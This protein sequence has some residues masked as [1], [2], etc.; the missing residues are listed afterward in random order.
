MAEGNIEMLAGIGG[1]RLFY[2]NECSLILNDFVLFL[3][4]KMDGTDTLNSTDEMKGVY[5]DKLKLLL[6]KAKKEAF[7]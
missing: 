3:G 4:V 1:N 5:S 6:D 7:S 2:Y